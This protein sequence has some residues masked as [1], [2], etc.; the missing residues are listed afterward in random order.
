MNDSYR[1]AE[2]RVKKKPFKYRFDFEVGYLVKSPCRD[3]A[4]RPL[5]PGC[6]KGCRILDEIHSVMAESVSCSR[7]S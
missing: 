4:D 1:T 2:S 3:C 5:F 7:G 6:I